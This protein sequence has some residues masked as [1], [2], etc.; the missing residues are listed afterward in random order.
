MSQSIQA[1]TLV[2]VALAPLAGSLLAGIWGTQL[3]GAALGRR[4]SHSLTILGVFIS[5]VLSASTP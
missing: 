2:A 5:F 4:W 3:G 1:S